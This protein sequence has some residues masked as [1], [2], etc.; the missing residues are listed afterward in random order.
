LGIDG[1]WHFFFLPIIIQRRSIQQ[2]AEAKLKKKK[3]KT[4]KEPV[5]FSQFLYARLNPNN[6]SLII[7]EK[8]PWKTLNPEKR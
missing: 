6:Q 5:S 7:I 8:K 3:K 4:N 2:I 1:Q